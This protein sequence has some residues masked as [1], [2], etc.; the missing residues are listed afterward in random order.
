MKAL[1]T[2]G[3]GFIGRWIVKKLIAD[4][5]DVWVLDNLSNGQKENLAEFS[6]KLKDFVIGDIRD[7]RLLRDLFKKG[8]DV[9]F[10]LAAD[11]NLPGSIDNPRKTFDVNVLGTSNILE[12]VRKTRT[13]MLFV[14][15]AH[16]YSSAEGKAIDELHPTKPSSPYA[17]S[18]IAGE[19]MSLSFY[20]AYQL[21][22]VVI[23]PFTAYGPFQKSKMMEGGVTSIFI[24]RSLN[25]E[26]LLVFGDGTQTRDLFYVEDC[27]NFIVKA[28]LLPEANG[29]VI[30]AGSGRD[31]SINDLALFI[32][33]DAKRLKHVPHRYPQ[34]EVHKMVCDYSKAR[35]LLSWQPKI[36]LEEGIKRTIDWM[37]KWM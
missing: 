36:P 16:V 12:E 37:K 28:A 17:A 22:V 6:G 33:K 21:P 35:K 19:N 26:E 10:H 7:I 29:E 1:V 13:K 15:S 2:G 4:G 24:Q 20:H 23:R 30:N 3:A 11:I 32:S 8:F 9:C 34:S 31:I 14:S 25:N 27:A 5:N 18:K